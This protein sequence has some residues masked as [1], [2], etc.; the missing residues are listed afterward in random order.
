MRVNLRAVLA[1]PAAR[2][3]RLIAGKQH[4]VARVRQRA[5]RDGA[6]RGRR[7]PCRS[8]RST[9]AGSPD[10]C[11][12]ARFL[13]RRRS[14]CSLA[15]RERAQRP[16]CGLRA[17]HRRGSSRDLGIELVEPLAVLA[18][19][20]RRH[21]A[22]HV[23]RQ[24]RESRR[25]SSS[26]LIQYSNSSTRPSANAGMI[27]LPP[28]SARLVD[29][30]RQ[31]V[32]V[33]VR[34]VHAIAVGGLDEQHVGF[35]DRRRDRAARDGRSGR[36]RRRRESSC[37]SRPRC[38]RAYADP[39]RW[40]A[41]MNSTVR[42]GRHGHRPVVADRLQQRHRAIG[43]FDGE[44]R[45]RRADGACSPCDWRAPRLLPAACAASASTMC[46]RSA[47]AGVQ[48]MRPRKPWPTSRG[49]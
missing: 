31:R 29:D 18:E 28:R 6:A 39:S 3:G 36:D 7:S 32:A 33:V 37:P 8:T 22:V 19:H 1:A 10:S 9:I 2:A 24:L 15:V 35:G 14:P 46:A 26:R 20:R 44:E 43:V 12:V 11:T 23:D 34:L 21:R 47:V 4:R 13:D 38:T 16:R 27:T 25:S 40:P 30:P 42:P 45:Q 49:R 17:V 48:K 41:L 5:C